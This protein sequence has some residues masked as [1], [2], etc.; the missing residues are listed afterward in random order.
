MLQ[1]PFMNRVL[2]CLTVLVGLAFAMPNLFYS[3]VETHVDA[4][5][6]IEATGSTPELEAQRAVWPDILPA[7]P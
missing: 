7:T 4:V 2:I 6:T 3:K 1:I 5:R